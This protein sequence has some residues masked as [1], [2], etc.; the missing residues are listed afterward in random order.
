[1]ALP[2][3]NTKFTLLDIFNVCNLEYI[4]YI[5]H[6][7]G[8]ILL[9]HFRNCSQLKPFKY[10]H[11]RCFMK[12]TCYW[13]TKFQ[14]VNFIFQHSQFTATTFPQSV[15]DLAKQVPWLAW[16]IAKFSTNID[17][18]KWDFL[19]EKLSQKSGL[20]LRRKR[21]ISCMLSSRSDLLGQSG[22]VFLSANNSVVVCIWYVYYVND[23]Y[24]LY[25]IDMSQ[26]NN[27]NSQTSSGGP[28][29]IHC[30]PQLPPHQK[31]QLW[32]GQWVPLS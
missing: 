29:R 2:T 22:I 21:Q 16:I 19:A 17:R 31:P 12:C 23:L 7:G 13:E 30:F 28:Q 24:I 3:I 11:N 1:M 25:M 27:W 10:E 20:R 32:H 15:R 14:K 4:W 26:Q 8:G 6:N 18:K 5:Q 9:G